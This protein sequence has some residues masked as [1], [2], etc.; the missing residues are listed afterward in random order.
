ML[1]K[2]LHF[3]LLSGHTSVY[4]ICC[5]MLS[6]KWVGSVSFGCNS[7]YPSAT[8]CKGFKIIENYSLCAFALLQGIHHNDFWSHHFLISGL[9]LTPVQRSAKVQCLWLDWPE[10]L[11]LQEEAWGMWLFSRTVELLALWQKPRAGKSVFI[12]LGE[13][14]LIDEACH[15]C[16]TFVC[17]PLYDYSYFITERKLQHLQCKHPH[18]LPFPLKTS[19]IFLR[20]KVITLIKRSNETGIYDQDRLLSVCTSVKANLG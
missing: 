10:K 18:M 1:P 6:W 19:V 8:L 4:Q 13:L 20:L 12:V 11:H 2:D 5:K 14:F 3:C 17:F 9:Q 7:C 15:M 16:E